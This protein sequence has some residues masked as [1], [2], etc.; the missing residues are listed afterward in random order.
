VLARFSAS[1]IGLLERLERLEPAPLVER[2]E[3]LEQL[4]L[5]LF[6]TME[7]LNSAGQIEKLFP[8]SQTILRDLKHHS[9]PK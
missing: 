9:L 4:L 2:L 7:S 6:E 8:P 1:T 3:P 5:G